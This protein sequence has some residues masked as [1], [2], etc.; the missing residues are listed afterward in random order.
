[1]AVAPV[2]EAFLGEL[3]ALY[4][5]ATGDAA[6]VDMLSMNAL[7]S[8]IGNKS[9]PGEVSRIRRLL[10]QERAGLRPPPADLSGT[11]PAERLY[12][13]LAQ[14]GDE[15]QAAIATVLGAERAYDLRALAGGWPSKWSMA[16]CAQESPRD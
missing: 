7:V 14:I 8:E 2:L 10:A 9:E 3:R 5:E 6:G 16:G 13:L 1:E 11:S 15:T 12:R 4:L